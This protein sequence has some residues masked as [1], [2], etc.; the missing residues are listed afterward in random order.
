[1]ATLQGIR[2]ENSAGEPVIVVG[3]S[4]FRSKISVD[5]RYRYRMHQASRLW[6]EAGGTQAQAGEKNS[7]EGNHPGQVHLRTRAA[8]KRERSQ[9]D[10][11]FDD[12][13]ATDPVPEA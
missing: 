12:R 1:V 3:V 5:L 11:R 4:P 2:D 9:K 7:I 13:V 10:K 8:H 6:H